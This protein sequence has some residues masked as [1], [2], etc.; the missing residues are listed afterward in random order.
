MCKI[1]LWSF[2]LIFSGSQ[3]SRPSAQRNIE[4]AVDLYQAISLS[5]ENNIIFSPLG[6]TLGLG[7]VQLGAKG[8]ARQQIRQTL[9]LQE[10]SAG[11]EFSVL[12]S[13][14]S[15]I[16]EKKQEFT[17]NLANALYLQEGFTVKEQYLHS[18]KEFFQSA[19]KLVDFQDAKT[20][21]E[22]ISTWVESKTDGKI[23]DMFSEED[24]GPLTRLVLVNAIY[25]KGDWK[26]KFTK[27]STQLM[28]F[29]KKDGAA[30]KI[31]MMK[32]L[33]RTKY[34]DVHIEEMEKRITAHQ[35]LKWFSEVQEEEVEVSLP[36]FKVEQ[37]LDFKEALHSL[38]ITEIFSGGCDLSG[39]TDSAEVFV[40]QV[41]QYVFFE[42][43]EDGS[44]AATSTGMN[45]PVIMSLAHNQFIANHPFLFIVK[46]NPT[47]SIL[48]MGRVTN[49]DTQKMKGR[50]LDSL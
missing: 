29:T 34:E 30:V 28:N 41:M 6:T 17:F 5:H 21:A 11:E 1:L 25:F 26:Q 4:F 16:S 43:N 49:P 2:L 42:I 32:T 7:M 3:A 35:L 46:N 39:I 24:F 13:F 8:K 36:R 23:K 33:V 15:A 40:S 37:K 14:F 48:F 50:D 18:N 22:T 9:K 45:I 31:P 20:S 38:N 10:T 47:E 19:I 44:E 12:K 27:E